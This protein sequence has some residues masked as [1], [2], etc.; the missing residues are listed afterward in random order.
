[1]IELH[2]H[3][4]G[5]FR[6]RT[7]WE[8]AKQYGLPCATET[9]EQMRLAMEAPADCTDLGQ[10]LA[11]FEA[12]LAVQNWA[13]PLTR[14]TRELVEDIA[15]EGMTYA[16]LRFAPASCTKAGLT[17]AEAVEAV[18]LGARQG[19]QLCK[20]IRVGVIL[21]GMRGSGPMD[22]NL[23]TVEV[24]KHYLGDIVCAADLAGAEALFPTGDYEEMF[25]LA[26]RLGVPYTIHA[27]EAAG[28]E[29]VYAALEMGA[30]RIGHGIFAAQDP[31]L[32]RRLAREG[33]TLEVCLTSNCQTKAVARMEEHPIRQLFDAGVRVTLNTDNRTVSAT[34][35]PREIV[36]VKRALAFTD[37]EVATMQ[38]YARQAAFLK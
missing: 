23:E 13:E 34:T 16:E 35:L 3:L 2:L 7:V 8:V 5:S 20:N 4:D 30:K 29:S 1:M 26:R 17:Q 27:G 15:A 36:A 14:M 38:D 33:V 25:A 37:R 21:C 9:V 6:P 28:P 19:M 22:A 31:A 24:A 10:Y 12:P 18:L 32:V 11:R